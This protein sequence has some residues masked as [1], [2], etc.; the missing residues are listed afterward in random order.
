MKKGISVKR[1]ALVLL[2]VLLVTATVWTTVAFLVDRSP[3]LDNTFVPVAVACQV[4]EDFDPTANVKSNVSVQ[5]TGDI[6]A[7][8]RATV[9]VTWV[10]ENSGTTY[11]GAPKAEVD[12]TVAFAND[13]WEKGSDGFYYCTTPVL[14]GDATPTLIRSISPVAGRAPEGYVLSVQV[15]AS[16]IQSEPAEAVESA[17]KAVAVND[18][19]TITLR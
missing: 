16:A 3:S 2:A 12:Y 7:Y 6:S 9:V 17:W 8:V 5:N 18:G 4:R 13:G 11:G 14:P 10:S 15:I 19:G 1:T